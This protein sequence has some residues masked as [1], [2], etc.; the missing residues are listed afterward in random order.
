MAC[1]VYIAL[2]SEDSWGKFIH[3]LCSIYSA[4]LGG[5]MGEVYSWLV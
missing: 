2:C 1:V 5:F 3:G 4:M